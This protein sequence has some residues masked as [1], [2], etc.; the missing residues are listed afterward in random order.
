MDG[1]KSLSTPKKFLTNA[2]K[3]VKGEN[4]AELIEQFTSEMT[5]VAEGVCED[6]AKL[7]QRLDTLRNE[8]DQNLQHMESE[9]GALENA[10]KEDNARIE[11]KLD[12]LSARITALEKREERKPSRKKDMTLI[13]QITIPVAI[14]AAAWVIVSI[15]NLFR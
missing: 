6:Q 2:L 15:L 3:A 13:Q 7:H 14:A 5:L 10:V 1:N 8:G 11:R 4:T 9:F 12:E